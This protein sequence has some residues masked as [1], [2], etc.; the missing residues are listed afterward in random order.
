MSHLK[1]DADS[2]HVKFP[3]PLMLLA[4]LLVGGILNRFFPAPFVNETFRWPLG[5]LFLIVGLG[6]ILY[7]AK[8]F[9]KA[10]TKIEP[11]KTTSNIIQTGVY[12][13]SRNPI[14]LSFVVIGLGV[15]FVANSLWIAISMIP[16]MWILNIFV[17]QKEE[18][19]LATKFGSEYLDYK[20][21]VRRW[22]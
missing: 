6:I 14:Y 9:Q 12:K 4:M 15:A 5:I 3:P 7:S 10:Q 1:A 19:Y 16:L 11:W 22:L 2:A 21:R 8:L 17:I 18:K 20:S 13:Y